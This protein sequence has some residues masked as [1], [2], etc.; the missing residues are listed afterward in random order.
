MKKIKKRN[1][2]TIST[3]V[4]YFGTVVLILVGALS[5]KNS[6]LYFLCGLFE[7][8]IVFT[9]GQ[10]I[11]AKNKFLGGL[12]SSILLVIIFAQYAVLKLGGSFTSMIMVT[13]LHAVGALRGNAKTYLSA[14]V[15]AI[16]VFLLPQRRI[17]RRFSINLRSLLTGIICDALICSFG[18]TGYSP[19]LSMGKLGI[20]LYQQSQMEKQIAKQV[21]DQNASGSSTL[22]PAVNNGYKYPFSSQMPNVVL[23]FTEGLS[24][25]IVDDSRNIMPNVKKY[26]NNSIYFTNYF[27]HTAATFRGLIGQLHSGYQFND[28]DRN[29]LTSLQ[30]VLSMAGYETTFINPEPNSPDFTSYLQDF[31]FDHFVNGKNDGQVVYDDGMYDLMY[32]NLQQADKTKPQFMAMYTYGTHVSLDSHDVMYG[33]GTN[34]E[35]NKFYNDD[36]QFGKFMEKLENSELG[37][38]TL[39]VFTADHCTAKDQDYDNTFGA[40]HERKAFFCDE[41]PLLFWYKGVTP[42]KIDVNGRN[43]LDMAPTLLD[44]LNLGQ[45]DVFEGTS[46]FAT[47]TKKQLKIETTFGIP[48]ESLYYSTENGNIKQLSDQDT[49]KAV[50]YVSKYVSKATSAWNSK[51]ENK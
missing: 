51:K 33:D 40:V 3:A 35:L 5:Q 26:E 21:N 30:D 12:I 1:F 28:L 50:E 31:E 10:I 9:L 18:G 13:N 19:V 7:E 47:P 48:N 34:P 36:Y 14:V 24:Q 22:K 29:G 6:M 41:M 37:D 39:V 49:K 4:K 2:L 11:L 45:P 38:N 25:N 32:Q 44:F 16:I 15:M 43:T 20:Q 27:N 42:V 46:L 8:I 23:I 17:I